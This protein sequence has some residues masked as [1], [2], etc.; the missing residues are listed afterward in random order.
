[1]CKF[2]ALFFFSSTNQ[3]NQTSTTQQT[4]TTGNQVTSGGVTIVKVGGAQPQQPV[5]TPQGGYTRRA[6][7]GDSRSTGRLHTAA[8][9]NTHRSMT[10]LNIAGKFKSNPKIYPYNDAV[11]EGGSIGGLHKSMTRL[12]SSQQ[13]NSLPVPSSVVPTPPLS[14]NIIV[15]GSSKWSIPNSKVSSGGVTVTTISPPR[16]PRPHSQGPLTLITPMI[17][18][19]QVSDNE[20]KN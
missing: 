12:S 1:M 3:I 6:K 10:R 20:G 14:N 7:L 17:T 9:T 5:P 2:T 13:I 8:N 16:I 11:L 19:S 4:T 15:T 18:N